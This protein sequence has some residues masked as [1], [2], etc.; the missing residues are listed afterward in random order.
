MILKRMVCNVE[1]A[2]STLAGTIESFFLL[3][4]GRDMLVLIQNLF[5]GTR[6]PGVDLEPLLP[7]AGPCRTCFDSRKYEGLEF[8]QSEPRQRGSRLC[9]CVH[10]GR[11]V[12]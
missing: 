3:P 4:L 1:V 2:S 8:R 7:G 10:D 5:I 9:I 11:S 12:A 6:G